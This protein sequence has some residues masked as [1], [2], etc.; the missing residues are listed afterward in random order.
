M[1]ESPVARFCRDPDFRKIAALLLISIVCFTTGLFAQTVRLANHS[2]AAFDGWKRT[3]I[4]SEPPHVAGEL[5]G[6]R[7]VLGRRI[8]LEARVVDV[9]CSLAPGQ[10]LELDLAKAAAIDFALG[11]PPAD[12][13]AHFGGPVLLAGVPLDVVALAA[14][15]AAWTVQLRC[16]VGR[17]LCANIWLTWYPDQPGW[18]AGEVLVVA[19]NPSVPDLSATIPPAFA[20]RFGDALVLVPGRAPGDPLLAAGDTLADGQGRAL[21]LTFVWLRHLRASGWSSVGAVAELGVGA[22]GVRSLLPGGAP[23][24]PPGYSG[25]AWATAY[26]PAAVANLHRWSPGPLGPLPRS[27]D[28]GGQEDQV[29]HAGGEAL[30]R[31][32]VGAEVVRYLTAVRFAARPCQHL[33]ADGSPLDI[34]RHPNLLFWD[35]RPHY[36]LDVSPDQLGKPRVLTEADTHGWLGP[37]VQ[38]MY[39]RTLVASARL[40]GS[41]ACQWLLSRLAT[42]YLLQRTSNPAWSLSQAESAREW[43]CEG[44]FVVDCYRDLEDR[45]LAA[46]VVQRW[47]ERVERILVPQTAGKDLW[48]IWQNPFDPRLDPNG[49]GVQWWQESFLSYAVDLACE[50]VGPIEGRVV[51]RRVAERVLDVAWRQLPDGRWR[52]QPQGP[53]DG[54][55][56]DQ[57]PPTDSFNAFGMP[58]CVA[59]VLRHDRQHAKAR[60]VWMQLLA[61][62]GETARR[63]MPPGVR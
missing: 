13:L 30:L 31:D 36:R 51:A 3:T 32:G 47:R 11:S 63:W 52:S 21:P 38:H 33:E 37:D 9:H 14:D 23:L 26:W 44:L 19:S 8:G 5:G 7:Y 55:A 45:A 48:R 40:T 35:G 1:D 12:P 25:R 53:L 2:S 58:L 43:G 59:T 34:A 46:R 50:Q 22:V 49:P 24:F 17:M 16:R 57:N 42:V 28:P 4:D 15:G 54:S 10:H 29:F 20:L 18:C 60:A 39:Q 27:M 61:A 62:T 6:A 41:P 56:N